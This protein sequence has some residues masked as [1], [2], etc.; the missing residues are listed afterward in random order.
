MSTGKLDLNIPAMQADVAAMQASQHAIEAVA[1][2]LKGVAAQ[3]FGGTLVGTGADA[4]SDFSHQVDSAVRSSNEVVQR[5]AQV[6]HQAGEDTIGF[7]RGG[8]A[9]LYA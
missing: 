4:G 9:G 3:L 8:F 7:D 5:C 2:Q 1:D 6:V